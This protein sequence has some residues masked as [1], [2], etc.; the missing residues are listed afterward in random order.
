MHVSAEV[1]LYPL[2]QLNLSPMIFEALAIFQKHGLDVRPGSMSTL[3]SGDDAQI[4]ASLQDAWQQA[5][6]SGELVM[7]VALSNA[8]P[9]PRDPQKC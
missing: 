1:S 2:R 9:M 5:A 4:F 3:M 6:N 8:C 7:H